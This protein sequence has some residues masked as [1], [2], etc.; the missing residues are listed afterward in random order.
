MFKLGVCGEH[1]G[2]PAS[3]GFFHACGR[4]CLWGGVAAQRARCIPT[5]CFTATSV[6]DGQAYLSPVHRR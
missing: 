4:W 2:D 6:D 3:I 1:G 5:R